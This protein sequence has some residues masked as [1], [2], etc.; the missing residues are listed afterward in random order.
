MKG[1][2]FLPSYSARWVAMQFYVIQ[3]GLFS[4]TISFWHL[5]VPLNI[6]AII[7]NFLW[8]QDKTNTP[9][10]CVCGGGGGNS[11][12]MILPQFVVSFIFMNMQVRLFYI[13]LFDERT[14]QIVSLR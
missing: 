9:T 8:M 3:T 4:E 13:W 10:R 2:C 12:P 14:C 7:S 11:Y 1:T 6:F 5:V